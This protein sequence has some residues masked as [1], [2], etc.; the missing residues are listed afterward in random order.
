MKSYKVE[1]LE[2]HMCHYEVD[3]ESEAD[4]IQEALHGDHDGYLEFERMLE[5]DNNPKAYEVKDERSNN[6]TSCQKP[7]VPAPTS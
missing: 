1:V 2:V 3:A 5:S 7:G 6:Q 4:A